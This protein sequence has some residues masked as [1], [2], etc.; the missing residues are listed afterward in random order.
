[1]VEPK[2]CFPQVHGKGVLCNAKELSQSML[3]TAP[4]GFDFIDVFLL[5]DKFIVAVVSPEISINPG[6][7]KPIVAAPPICVDH[8]LGVNCNDPLIFCSGHT[9]ERRTSW[10]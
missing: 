6:I 4:E 7:H 8:A 9:F 1:M 3:G 5:P 10:V 2:F